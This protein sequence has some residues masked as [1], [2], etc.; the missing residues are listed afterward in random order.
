MEDN[1]EKE[2]KISKAN[3]V[4]FSRFEEVMQRL[5]VLQEMRWHLLSS[6]PTDDAESTEKYFLGNEMIAET[7][8]KLWAYINGETDTF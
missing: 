1:N 5:Y 7:E 8:R 4:R 3:W 6:F 2:V